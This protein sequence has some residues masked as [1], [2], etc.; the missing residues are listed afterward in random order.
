MAF[1]AQDS[2]E[3]SLQL[4]GRDRITPFPHIDISPDQMV[5]A[6]RHAADDTDSNGFGF[7]F[8]L[9]THITLHNNSSLYF[10]RQPITHRHQAW[11]D[12]HI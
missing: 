3:L 2:W 11:Q 6:D 5:F 4:G 7:H 1:L 10:R 12:S 9:R 8:A